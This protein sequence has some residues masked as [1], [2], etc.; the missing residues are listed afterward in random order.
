VKINKKERKM[1]IAIHRLKMLI[2]ESMLQFPIGYMTSLNQSFETEVLST[3]ENYR[4]LKVINRFPDGCQVVLEMIFLDV[5]IPG[6]LSLYLAEITTLDKMGNI[7]DECYKKGYASN[8]LTKF[9][10]IS[11][12]YNIEIDLT[13]ASQDI[14]RFP[15]RQLVDFYKRHGFENYGNPNKSWVEMSRERKSIREMYSPNFE[16][17]SLMS[18]VGSPMVKQIVK[19]LIPYKDRLSFEIKDTSDSIDIKMNFDGGYVGEIGADF[20]GDM[21]KNCYIVGLSRTA[22]GELADP[23]FPAGQKEMY[24]RIHPAFQIKGYGPILYE[25][26]LELV[27]RRGPD[28]Y[29]TPDR[30]SLSPDAYKVWEYYFYKRDDVEKTQLDPAAI[31]GSHNS[32]PEK[33]KHTPFDDSDDCDNQ[34]S[35]IYYQQPLNK[36]TE[37]QIYSQGPEDDHLIDQMFKD[38]M[39]HVVNSDPIMKGY[40]K[41]STPFLSVITKLRMIK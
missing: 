39:D 29:L 7:S 20:V 28:I 23:D 26:C 38:Y 24:R 3:K 15:N 5:R 1:K 11:D 37:A 6:E 34:T 30:D 2:K 25:L 9:L 16:F 33:F 13:A 41:N 27:S 10:K 22:A 21:C 4:I 17:M 19:Y 18:D 40:R 35:E 31:P 32:I 14:K 8:T 12:A 36:K